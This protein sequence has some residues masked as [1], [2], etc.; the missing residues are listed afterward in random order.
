MA[1]PPQ[2]NNMSIARTQTLGIEGTSNDLLA[3]KL[4]V[5]LVLHPTAFQLLLPSV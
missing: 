4:G 3:F 2:G 5:E 1:W